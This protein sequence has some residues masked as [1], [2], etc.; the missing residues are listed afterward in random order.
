MPCINHDYVPMAE[1]VTTVAR[2]GF[3]QDDNDRL[4]AEN[5]KLGEQLVGARAAARA[6][7]KERD[8]AFCS[9][10]DMLTTEATTR[11]ERDEYRD[12]LRKLGDDFCAPTTI[13]RA[14]GG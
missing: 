7:Q 1:H 11:A 13:K 5:R 10:E 2:V 3:L 14:G 12:Q 6:L 9:F 8:D 4:V